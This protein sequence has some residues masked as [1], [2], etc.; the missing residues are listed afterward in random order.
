MRA[1]FLA[2]RELREV[3]RDYAS[4]GA[5]AATALLDVVEVGD[6]ARQVDGGG[7]AAQQ[8]GVVEAL[9]GWARGKRTCCGVMRLAGSTTSSSRM[10][11]L[12]SWLTWSHSLG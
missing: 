2:G 10:K 5:A 4:R 11:S 3:Q 6:D 1:L 9:R 12:A 8:P 7:A